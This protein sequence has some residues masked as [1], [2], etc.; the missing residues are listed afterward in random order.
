MDSYIGINIVSDI[1]H[2]ATS[3]T[4]PVVDPSPFIPRYTTWMSMY[5]KAENYLYSE[6]YIR[7]LKLFI[8][9][10]NV[11]CDESILQVARCYYYGWGVDIDRMEAIKLI[12]SVNLTDFPI[13]E[14]ILRNSQHLEE[15]IITDSRGLFES[16]FPF[17]SVRLTYNQ[18]KCIELLKE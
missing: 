1:N 13:I 7:A 12:R 18:R 2:W 9:L 4:T 10:A 16:A 8:P 3:V 14:C 11:G 15:G 17:N 5:A 6:R